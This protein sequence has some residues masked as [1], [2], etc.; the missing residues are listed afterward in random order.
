MRAPALL[1]LSGLVLAIAACATVEPP[2]GGA[3]PGP[4]PLPLDGYDWLLTVHDET[5]HLAYGVPESDDLR[6]AF[7]CQ[8]RSGRVGLVTLAGDGDEPVI[9]LES[10]GETERF[11]ADAEP[12]ELHEALILTAETG[13][14]EPVLQR[15]RRVGWIAQWRDGQRDA[16]APHPGSLPYIEDFFAFCG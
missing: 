8:Q 12:S 2:P 16:Y 5:A 1:A 14:S 3:A 10:G 7:N 15:F 13:T 11:E 6:L 4:A 9:F